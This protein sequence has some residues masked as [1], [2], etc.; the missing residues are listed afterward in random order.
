MGEITE[1]KI[2]GHKPAKDILRYLQTLE[3]DEDIESITLHIS[4]K[5][6]ERAQAT[7]DDSGDV[8]AEDDEDGGEEKERERGSIRS[9]TSHH[10]VL[11]TVAELTNNGSTS[12]SSKDVVENVEGVAESS[13][14]PALTQLWE[15]MMIEREHVDDVANPYYKY[16]FTEHGEHTLEDLGKPEPVE[17]D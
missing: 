9:D 4:R 12:V 16:Y 8:E 14:Y 15:R 11:A 10:R 13:V 7:F 2:T 5:T 3:D 1:M 17:E 6:D